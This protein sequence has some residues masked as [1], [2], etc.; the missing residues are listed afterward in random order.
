MYR[1]KTRSHLRNGSTGLLAL[2]LLMLSAC[3]QTPEEAT[4]VVVYDG[5]RLIVG[6]GSVIENATFTVD[7]GRVVSA[8]PSGEVSIPTGA[9]RHVLSE[10]IFPRSY[11]GLTLSLRHQGDYS[12]TRPDSRTA[13]GMM[14][15]AISA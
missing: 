3:D 11:S 7:D 8:G 10:M 12:R 4:T 15:I 5:A 1:T 13:D 2:G 14:R 9:G 6:N